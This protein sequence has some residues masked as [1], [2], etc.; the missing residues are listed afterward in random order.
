MARRRLSRLEQAENDFLAA[1][2]RREKEATYE[3]AIRYRQSIKTLTPL[4]QEAYARLAAAKAAGATDDYLSGFVWSEYRQA[5]LLAQA[6]EVF[7]KIGAE[8]G[9]TLSRTQEQAALAAGRSATQ[10]LATELGLT[11]SAA[12]AVNA[13]LV[14]YPAQ[15][16]RSLTGRLQ[17]G[18]P[19]STLAQRYGTDGP[20]LIRNA[21]IAGVTN[22]E[23]P[24]VVARRL[25]NALGGHYGSM[26]LLARTEMLRVYRDGTL[27]VYKSNAHLVRGWR[28][29]AALQDS[30][31]PVCWALHGKVFPLTEPFASHPACRCSALPVLRPWSEINPDLRNV[32]DLPEPRTGPQVFSKLP[33]ARQRA[34]LGPLNYK[35]YKQGLIKLPDLV[36]D[37]WSSEWGAGRRQ[38][39]LISIIGPTKMRGLRT[40]TLPPAPKPAP[41]PAPTPRPRPTPAPIPK[42]LVIEP[43]PPKLPE[44]PAPKVLKPQGT[45]VSAGV[46]L[47]GLPKRGATGEIGN[48]IR[49][50]Q[51]LIDDVHGDGQLPTIP[52]KLDASRSRYGAFSY[53]YNMRTPSGD[54]TSARSLSPTDITVSKLNTKHPGMT[55]AHEVGHYIDQQWLGAR[56]QYGQPLR[57]FT[58]DLDAPGMRE[59]WQAVQNTRAIGTL[60]D[61]Q[62]AARQRTRFTYPKPDG[63]TGS[64]S[65]DAQ[66]L[67]YALSPKEVWARSYAQY[68]AHR[69]Q[70]PSLLRQLDSERN[71]L[72]DAYYATQW[73]DDDFEVIADAFDALFEMFGGLG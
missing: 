70:D 51:G 2:F 71:P 5:Q 27:N 32:R 3:L 36:Q 43:E 42:A 16:L 26:A 23:S 31:C 63:T 34:I 58:D 15:Q 39:S 40:G 65:P 18:S 72:T 56:N 73:A 19:I 55:Y 60:T 7:A 46:D 69:T 35:A 29:S 61:M 1:L 30:T 62:Q 47:T 6:A 66:Y 13:G 48:E 59:W 4:W 54:F 24:L 52:V 22:G 37:T 64:V 49:R 20:L 10:T 53:R 9:L 68:I 67:K 28:W 38:R 57:Y 17:D 44:P 11:A 21:L 12:G 45:P 25:R 50:V 33:E 41:R 14:T 8:T